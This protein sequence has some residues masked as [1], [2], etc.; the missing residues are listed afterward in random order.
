MFRNSLQAAPNFPNAL[1][2]LARA[3]HLEWLV[4]ARG[5][6]E[7]LRSSEMHARRAIEADP[8]SPGGYHQLGVT[9]LYDSDFDES[10]GAFEQAERLA[11]SHADLIADYADTLVHA[12]DPELAIQKI[13][14]AIDLN[15]LCPDV[16]W[17][18]AS[19]ANYCLGKF[20]TAL[21]CVGKMD[22]QSGATRLAAACWGM[23]GDTAKARRLMR[24]TMAIYPD[25]EV[26]R[27]LSIMPLKES[28]H[29]EQYREGLRR[30]G[31]K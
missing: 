4:T 31:F 28:W 5:D 24:K 18:T 10:V 17:W 21:E 8:R 15:P 3:E 1:S 16:Y 19:G 26:E 13:E 7:L 11:P 25:F 2:G 27:W 29:K 22:D 12:S 20:E 9:R 30:A 14:K 23:L 6:K